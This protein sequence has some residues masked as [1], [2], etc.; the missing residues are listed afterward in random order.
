MKLSDYERVGHLRE[1]YRNAKLAYTKAIQ[2]EEG[3]HE[4][5]VQVL[6]R[7]GFHDP[8]WITV[9]LVEKLEIIRGAADALDHVGNLLQEAGVTPD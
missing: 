9:G 5:R 7:D 1:A 6:S 3:R 2:L 4:V 8:L